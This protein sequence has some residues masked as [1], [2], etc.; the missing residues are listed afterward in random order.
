MEYFDYYLMHA[1][2]R[3]NFKHFVA[4]NAYETAFRLKEEGKVRH[5]GLSFHDNAETLDKILTA[6]PQVEVVQ[7]QFNYLDYEDPAIQSRA[8]YEVCQKHGKPVIVME[9][10]KGGR[11]VNLPEKASKLLDELQGGSHASYA[12]RF[13]A[14]FENI[15]M[16]LSGMGDM[17]MM[18]D[19]LSYMQDFKPLNDR[20]LAAVEAVC[21]QLRSVD[22]I[23][24]TA[25]KYCME[26]CPQQIQI[27]DLFA[28]LNAKRQGNPEYVPAENAA[29]VCLRCGKC[30]E[31]CPQNLKIRE[32]LA[33]AFEE[34]K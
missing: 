8:C 17:Q 16:V 33:V 10:V 19:N 3:D 26:V 29:D 7:L 9:P 20:E 5:V 32:L 31:L 22:L 25:C 24:C 23:P 11:L 13:A 21:K 4:C 1:Q 34:L 2:N 15:K 18:T 27:P 14:S 28:E 12:I 6:Y 30:E